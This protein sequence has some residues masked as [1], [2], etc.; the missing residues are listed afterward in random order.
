M[1]AILEFPPH[2]LLQAL[3]ALFALL[4]GHAIADFPLQGEYLAT[5]KN[6]RLLARLQDPARPE[7][8]WIVCMAAHCLIHAGTVW[9]ITGSSLL[10]LFEFILHWCIDVAKCRGKT[11]FNQDQTLHLLCK[12][13]YIALG[14]LHWLS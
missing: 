14:Y 1:S 2:T 9:L 8:I 6:R 3:Q 11:T 7:Q 13:S 12:M 4:I 10:G 5:G